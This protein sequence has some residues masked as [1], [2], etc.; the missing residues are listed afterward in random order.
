MTAA[1]PVGSSPMSRQSRAQV[2]STNAHPLDPAVSDTSGPKGSFQ[3]LNH[4]RE[5]L[6]QCNHY[7]K[8]VEAHCMMGNED[9]ILCNNEQSMLE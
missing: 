7:F 5:V 6:I 2:L 3:E 4:V 9:I 1:E 8:W